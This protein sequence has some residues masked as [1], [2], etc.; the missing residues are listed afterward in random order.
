MRMQSTGPSA[1]AEGDQTQNEQ[2]RGG[3]GD[4]ERQDLDDQRGPEI[5]AEHDCERGDQANQP[6]RRERTRNQCGGRAAL[7]QCR[8]ADAGRKGRK[9]V[10]QSF[11]QTTT[12]IRTESA[13]NS[14]VDHV[15]APQQQ[16][17]A[18]HQVEKNQ[19]THCSSVSL[20]GVER[21]DYRQST[22]DQSFCSR[23]NEDRGRG[24]RG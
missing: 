20:I 12:E 17:H 15:Q 4:V 24:E 10:L 16:R 8:Q 7:E 14:A 9:P 18:T 22:G 3:G 5:C 6:I 13:E 1:A 23:V 2:D 19:A 11:G 21:S